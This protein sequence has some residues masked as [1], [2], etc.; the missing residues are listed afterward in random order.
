[1]ALAAGDFTVTKTIHL[2]KGYRK[3]IGRYT[4]SGTYTSGGEVMTAAIANAKLGLSTID[5][6]NFTPLVPSAGTTYVQLVYDH[7]AVGTAKIH[8]SNAVAAHTHNITAIGGLVSSE[9]LFLDASQ[10][11]G[12]AAATDRTIVGS[13][14]ATT[15]G[16]AVNTAVTVN[17][18]LAA[19]T[20]ISTYSCSFVAYGQRA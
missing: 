9:A 12:K 11:F 2:G 5:Y 14:S 19:S 15:G 18:E 20:D 16:V 1:M 10:K 13:T 17:T 8:A 3:V 4:P 6:M 7:A